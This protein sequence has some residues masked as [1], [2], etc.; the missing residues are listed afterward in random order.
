VVAHACLDVCDEKNLKTVFASRRGEAET[1]LKILESLAR[2]EP[3][4]PN[5]FSL[6]VHNTASG[7]FSI[8]HECTAPSTAL[9][10]SGE[11]F[12]SLFF[13]TFSAL[14]G[15]KQGKVLCVLSDPPLP[16][17]FRTD[18][19]HYPMY[20]VAMILS[21]GEAGTGKTA[22]QLQPRAEG[23]RGNPATP[24]SILRWLVGSGEMP[25]E[26]VEGAPFLLRRT[27]GDIFDRF[28][29]TEGL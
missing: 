10:A 21:A 4:S 3:I 6:S 14:E 22:I 17:S 19:L 5:Q 1:T 26:P 27:P 8:V 25:L 18:D 15:D 9:A 13:E 29:S 20:A 11:E 12:F 2:R 28:C 16:E 24:E 7:L 23:E